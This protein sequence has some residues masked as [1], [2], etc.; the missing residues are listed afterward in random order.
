MNTK[1]EA[2]VKYMSTSNFDTKVTAWQGLRGDGAKGDRYIITGTSLMHGLL[3][4]GALDG[5][6]KSYWVDV[7]GAVN[8]SVYGPDDLGGGRLRLVGSCNIPNE[9]GL[10]HSGFVWE[11]TVSD[12]P[13]GGSFR[14]IDYPGATIQFT[15]STMGGL[16]VGN[17]DGPTQVGDQSLPLGT[18]KAYLYDVASGAFLTDVVFPGSKGNTVYGIWHNGG[19]RYTLCG[20][21]SPAE[22][23]DTLQALP[24]LRAFLVDYD[25]EAKT[26]SNWTAFDYPNGPK[27]IHFVTH[28]EG[29]SSVEP[30]V[31]TVS[32][33]S[34]QTGSANVQQG[35]WVEITRRADGGF[36]GGR[37]VD[38]NY[39]GTTRAVT[40]S[41]SVYGNAVVGVTMDSDPIAYQA[42][43][44]AA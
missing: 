37:W 1:N 43:I 2:P 24:L 38:L 3:Y 32:A 31:Y 28:F 9:H 7:P 40:S 41:N 8:T 11:G 10:V 17:A 44:A 6:G 21:F 20:G 15:H 34:A 18:S 25:A 19:A 36:D 35:S 42:I 22:T 39:P 30:G 14:T 12:L 33:D 4:I 16:A 23:G 29:I 27:G 5:G 26:F 13:S